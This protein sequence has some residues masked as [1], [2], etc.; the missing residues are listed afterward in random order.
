MRASGGDEALRVLREMVAALQSVDREHETYSGEA[1]L[2]ALASFAHGD[3]D[4]TTPRALM[5]LIELTGGAWDVGRLD[6]LA[7]GLA[8]DPVD[9]DRFAVSW[10]LVRQFSL[11]GADSE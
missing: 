10:D 11:G 5:A 8:S 1:A 7:Q 4:E 6:A 3:L 9:G 2:G